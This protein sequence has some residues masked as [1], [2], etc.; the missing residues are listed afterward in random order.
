MPVNI[1]KE[2]IWFGV[3]LILIVA[4]G[5][6]WGAGSLETLGFVL[7]LAGCAHAVFLKAASDTGHVT[8]EKM[9]ERGEWQVQDAGQ[10]ETTPGGR[11]LMRVIRNQN[12]YMMVVCF[13]FGLLMIVL[14]DYV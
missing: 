5:L 1:R 11:A 4:A 9:N 8:F 12:L 10:A 2:V 6:Y 14:A 7:L 13:V 3:K